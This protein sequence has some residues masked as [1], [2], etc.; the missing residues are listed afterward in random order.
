MGGVGGRPT[1]RPERTQE[2][3]QLNAVWYL[4]W[5]PRTEIYK[6]QSWELSS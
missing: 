3:R 2:I 1:R 6:G 5:D 4:G